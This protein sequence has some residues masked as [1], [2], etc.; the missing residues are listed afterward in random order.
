M[1]ES[2]E[3]RKK[4]GEITSTTNR[5]P[6]PSV[7]GSKIIDGYEVTPHSRP[8]MVQLLI[9]AGGKRGGCG[10]FLITQNVLLT[11]AHCQ[12][13]RITAILGSHNLNNNEASR[14]EIAV[15]R[16]IPHELYDSQ[17]NQNDIM[18][19]QLERKVMIT[20]EVQTIKFSTDCADIWPGMT[21]SVAG[22]GCT[23]TGGP[24]S[25][26]LREVDVTIQKI[27]RSEQCYK[28]RRGQY[29]VQWALESRGF[30]WE[31]RETRL[32]LGTN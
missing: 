4:I 23:F 13:E 19:L 7:S 8:Y 26:V 17:T 1:V 16:M 30:V 24:V 18:L 15:S 2:G 5:D 11:A 32:S 29:S 21:C 27:C 22:W 6:A 3:R 10:A 20:P 25:N 28:M 14:Q 9:T 12:G 31:T